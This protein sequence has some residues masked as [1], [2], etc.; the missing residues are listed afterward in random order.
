MVNQSELFERAAREEDEKASR[1]RNLEIGGWVVTGGAALVIADLIFTGG[2]VTAGKLTLEAVAA[3][4]A[5]AV[6]GFTTF[7]G[8]VNK[9]SSRGISE[10]WRNGARQQKR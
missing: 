1:G 3:L 8:R 2:L 5:A 4:I 9:N 7:V 6:G 10:T